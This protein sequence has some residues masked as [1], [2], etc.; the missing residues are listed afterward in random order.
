MSCVSERPTEVDEE[1]VFVAES[2]YN[3]GDKEIRKMIGLK[4]RVWQTRTLL[5]FVIPGLKST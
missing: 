5:T 1:D 2:R 3:E 4:V